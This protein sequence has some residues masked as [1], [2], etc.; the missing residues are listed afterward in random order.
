MCIIFLNCFLAGYSEDSDYTSDFNYPIGQHANSSASQFRSAAQL[1]CTPQRSLET[2][3][4]NSY[5][6]DDAPAQPNSQVTKFVN[7]SGREKNVPTIY[8][9]IAFLNQLSFLVSRVEASLRCFCAFCILFFW[10][11]KPFHASATSRVAYF[12]PNMSFFLFFFRLGIICLHQARVGRGEALMAGGTGAVV[13]ETP[14][15][16]LSTTTVVP[17]TIRTIPGT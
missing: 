9:K 15:R 14:R 6:R 5:E 8:G 2:S 17:G 10:L 11:G 1:M 13:S 7:Q 12:E 4:E 16:N 3:R